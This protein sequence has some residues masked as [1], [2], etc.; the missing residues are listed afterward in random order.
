MIKWLFF[1]LGWT[2]VDETKPHRFRWG[3]VSKMLSEWHIILSVDELMDLSEEAATHFA[4]SPFRTALAELDLSDSQR[5][6]IFSKVYYQREYDCLYSGVQSVLDTL[7]RKYKIGIIAN[8][9]LGT[10]ERLEKWGIDKYISLVI[11]SEEVGLVKP[12]LRIF[13][14]ALNRTE[15]DSNEVILIGDR[16][17]ND[18][19]PANCL[20]WKTIRVRQGFHRHQI[21]R[22]KDEEPDMTVDTIEDIPWAIENLSSQ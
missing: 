5:D 6:T 11:A 2:L 8:Q 18:I 10:E 13:N 19:G 3:M 4:E 7:Y 17:E 15:C 12:D 16:L 21:P 9:P 1:D 14:L 22:N 20:G